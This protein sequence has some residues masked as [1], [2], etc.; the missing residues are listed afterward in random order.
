MIGRNISSEELAREI[1]KDVLFFEESGGGVTFG[2]GEPLAQPDFLAAA[3]ST[4]RELEIHTAVDSCGFAP[5][6]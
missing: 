3:L 5:C 1:E 2:G 4:V 6:S